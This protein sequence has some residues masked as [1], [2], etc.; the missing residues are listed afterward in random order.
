MSDETEAGPKPRKTI[1]KVAGKE[2]DLSKAAPLTLGDMRELHRRGVTQKKL[3]ELANDMDWETG[4]QLFYVLSHKVDPSI[5]EK[6]VEG[7]ALDAEHIGA[8][9]EAVT[10]GGDEQNPTS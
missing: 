4:F 3:A 8:L 1:I 5:T 7:I 10:S 2:V 9:M 6:D